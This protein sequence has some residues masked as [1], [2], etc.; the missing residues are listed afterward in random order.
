MGSDSLGDLILEVRLTYGMHLV[1]LL[2][3]KLVEGDPGDGFPGV[4]VWGITEAGDG[5]D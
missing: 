3:N 1:L 2:G 4:G 5:P